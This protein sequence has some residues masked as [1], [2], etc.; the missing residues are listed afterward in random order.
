MGQDGQ[1][2]DVTNYVAY[3]ID[4]VNVDY[5]TSPPIYTPIYHKIVLGEEFIF[6][7]NFN[8]FT[9]NKTEYFRIRSGNI[10]K[11]DLYVNP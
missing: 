5:N 7:S 2:Y 8:T 6:R 3:R 10:I 4:G 1:M 9:G 11:Y